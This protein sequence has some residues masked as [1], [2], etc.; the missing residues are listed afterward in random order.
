MCDGFTETKHGK[1]NP[2]IHENCLPWC[3]DEDGVKGREGRH[4]PLSITC[5]IVLLLN[6]VN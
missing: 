4:I 1:K 5:D 3:V 6:H 2:E